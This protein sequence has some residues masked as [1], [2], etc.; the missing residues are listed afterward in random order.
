MSCARLPEGQDR[1]PH[2]R[3][4]QNV[5]TF[6][7]SGAAVSLLKQIRRILDDAFAGE[8]SDDD[9]EHTLGGLHVVVME[10]DTPLAHAA[11]VARTLEVDGRPLRTGYVEGVA[12]VANRHGEGLGSLAM[13]QAMH[14][15]R[16]EF[17]LGALSTSRHGFYERL[18]WERWRGPTFVRHGRELVR[19]EGED[20]GVM[21]LR[22]GHSLQL[23]L[24]API[25]CEARTGDDW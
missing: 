16:A 14:V 10:S 17:E 6:A 9:W 13:S 19:S 7:T 2:D 18:G 3:E 25:S 20:E 22:F 4:V 21:V 12:T 15:L 24:D 11:V 8:F 1:I 23:D 5:Q